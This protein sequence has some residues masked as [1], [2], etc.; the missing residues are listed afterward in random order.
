MKH[1]AS[2]T[3]GLALAASFGACAMAARPPLAPQPDDSALKALVSDVEVLRAQSKILAVAGELS[4]AQLDDVQSLA[5][6]AA[7]FGGRKW[8]DGAQF[9]QGTQ[10]AA[11]HRA[12]VGSGLCAVQPSDKEGAK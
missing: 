6:L 8:C 12:Y 2:I 4:R 5:A 10:G 11:A 1:F 7:T 9:K 3:A